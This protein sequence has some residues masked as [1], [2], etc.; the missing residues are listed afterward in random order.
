M[1]N[2][3]TSR[4][5]RIQRLNELLDNLIWYKDSVCVCLCVC[6]TFFCYLTLLTTENPEPFLYHLGYGLW[7]RSP[8]AVAGRWE[9]FALILLCMRML[10]HYCWM[11]Y[12][13]LWKVQDI[14]QG[15]L[16][17]TYVSQEQ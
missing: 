15:C 14:K 5:E 6:F 7:Y 12:V 3:Y 11:Q 9:N 17:N 10:V 16:F 8:G 2:T 13:W 4:E 1:V